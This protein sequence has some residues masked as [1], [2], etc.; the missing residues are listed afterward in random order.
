MPSD[1]FI[2]I[3]KN[4][5]PR[6]YIMAFDVQIKTRYVKRLKQMLK[7]KKLITLINTYKNNLKQL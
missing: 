3:N 7:I 1:N 4:F 6:K 5:I 2:K